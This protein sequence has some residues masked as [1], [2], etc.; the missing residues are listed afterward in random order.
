MSHNVQYY[1]TQ[2]MTMSKPDI[3]LLPATYCRS[4]QKSSP[5]MG[6]PHLL[7]KA[8]IVSLILCISNTANAIQCSVL[9]NARQCQSL[10]F[11]LTHRLIK[12]SP[13]VVN[14]YDALEY[15]VGIAQRLITYC[16][17]RLFRR[18]PHLLSTTM[19]LCIS[20]SAN[21]IQRSVL[22]NAR[23]CQ[24]LINLL[25]RSVSIE[26]SPFVTTRCFHRVPS[27]RSVV[28]SNDTLEYNVIQCSVLRNARL[29]TTQ[30]P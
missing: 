4:F 26:I 19:I 12:M 11:A 25:L 28:N 16:F 7:S 20:N 18:S 5:P 30:L 15:N 22:R 2:E 9:C 8:M 14:S 6:S 13:Y 23:H 21:V 1:A 27:P 29:S 10:I 24:S 17:H 3:Q